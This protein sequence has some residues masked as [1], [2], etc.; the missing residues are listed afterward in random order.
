M[1]EYK[2]IK[3]GYHGRLL[4]INLSNKTVQ[5]ENIP[6][7]LLLDYIG[8]RGLGTKLLYDEVPSGTD[9]LSPNNTIYYVT[10]PFNGTGAT[11]S[12]RFS[13]VTKSPLTG[14]VGGCNSGGHFG[15][16]LKAT[17]FDVIAIEGKAT[18]PSYI[19]VNGEDVEIR[20]AGHL[21]GKNIP[22][23]T[24]LLLAEAGSKA[25]V[26]CIGPA[27]EEQLLLACI[28]NDKNHA[29][30]RGGMGAVM[31]S[32][33]LKALVVAGEN[34]TPVAD[35]AKV[36]EVKKSWQSFIGE[37]PLTKDVLKEHGTPSLARVI[38]SYGAFPVKNFQ[39][40]VFNDVDSISAE[41]FK[42]LYYTKSEPCRGC[43]IGCAHLSKTA[44]RSGKGPEFESLWSLGALCNISDFEAIVNA[45]YNCNELGIDTIS[46]G[47][48]IAC[49]MELSERGYFDADAQKLIHDALGRELKFGDAEAMLKLSILT[50]KG[51]G[52]GKYISMGSKRL[53][54]KYGHPELAMQ[55]KG[56]E[57][58]A[59]DAR[60]FKGMSIAYATS[61]RGG[62]HLR[63]YTV[64][65]EGVATP[66]AI[67]RFE[68]KGK[69][70]LVKLYQENTAMIDSMGVCLFTAFALNPSLYAQYLSAVTGVEITADA[71]LKTGERIWNLERL[72]NNR[73]GF[74]QKD[75]NL[76]N[77]ILNEPFPSGKSKG[78]KIDLQ[79]LL[80][81]YYSIRGWSKEGLPCKEKLEELGL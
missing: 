66:F 63:C 14:T 53:A 27:G 3:G 51:E 71:Y 79:P 11:T 55:V 8:G 64:A 61:N 2:K 21:W 1:S 38:N 48:S 13:A 49:A 12:S 60:G 72:Y 50:G 43:T 19:F 25:A 10:G 54:E 45:N 47:S 16:I 67:D 20:N 40:G 56:L 42:E 68:G 77:R 15:V 34:K 57:L 74:T 37:A 24:D 6:E 31:G 39:E 41:T 78:V 5:K 76:P 52:I 58:P 75:D 59:Y 44:T 62:C 28:I 36:N 18:G 17:G 65:P 81:E 22:E 69:S 23:T 26:S 35:E 9:A 70:M 73:E 46:A 33:N 7:K 80:Q 29:L 30:G 32:K 4:R